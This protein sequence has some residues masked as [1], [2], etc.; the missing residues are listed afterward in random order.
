MASRKNNFMINAHLLAQP[1][2][3]NLR[4]IYTTSNLNVEKSASVL[5]YIF[6][7][8]LLLFVRTLYLLYRNDRDKA[9]HSN[10]NKETKK[11]EKQNKNAKKK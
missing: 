10:N 5:F 9:E 3:V 1:V 7:Y 11:K 4:S 6:V 8:S 2:K